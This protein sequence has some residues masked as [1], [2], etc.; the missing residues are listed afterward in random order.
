MLW[1]GIHVSFAWGFFLSNKI[2]VTAAPIQTQFPVN[3]LLL[4][5]KALAAGYIDWMR[6]SRKKKLAAF[7]D[8][9]M[10]CFPSIGYCT[11]G[12]RDCQATREH[13][14][15]LL[16]AEWM[17]HHA[18]IVGSPYDELYTALLFFRDDGGVSFHQQQ[19]RS[20]GRA[21]ASSTKPNAG[22]VKHFRN[23]VG[24]Q[25]IKTFYLVCCLAQIR[26]DG[27][28][29]SGWWN[30]SPFPLKLQIVQVS[31]SG[32]TAG[33]YPLK[34]VSDFRAIDHC[35]DW[36]LFLWWSRSSVVTGHPVLYYYFVI[37]DDL[38]RNCANT[39]QFV[40]AV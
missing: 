37:R 9:C 21:S 23:L 36:R 40:P 26:K 22:L 20:Q 18:Y 38:S 19:R 1:W 28:R 27:V 16:A 31:V 2:D 35:R 7:I 34:K 32:T 12:T 13:C 14:R 33:W 17:T 6:D 11:V 4:F 5:D 24:C 15:K 29:H 39:H 30:K 8:V 25:S 3:C 10:N